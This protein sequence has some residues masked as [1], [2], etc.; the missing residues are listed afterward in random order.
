MGVENSILVR[1]RIWRTGRHTSS[2]EFLGVFICKLTCCAI[3][4]Y[5]E[6]IST[7]FTNVV[8]SPDFILIRKTR[9]TRMIRITRVTE[10]TKMALMNN[11][12]V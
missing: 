6:P 12:T 2:Q 8:R 4:P 1:L 7:I 10:V 3:F 9:I 5:L 11:V